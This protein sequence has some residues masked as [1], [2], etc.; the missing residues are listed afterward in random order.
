MPQFN[1]LFGVSFMMY[2]NIG[3]IAG[4]IDILGVNIFVANTPKGEIITIMLILFL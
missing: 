4:I 1:A 2:L 3:I